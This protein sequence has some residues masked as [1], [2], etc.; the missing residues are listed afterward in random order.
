MH[1]CLLCK[2][3]EVQYTKWKDNNKKIHW[4]KE[5]Y[6]SILPNWNDYY[7]KNKRC[8]YYEKS[9]QKKGARKVLY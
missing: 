5:C 2:Y 1:D 4:N 6:C 7:V 3:L 8:K 9:R